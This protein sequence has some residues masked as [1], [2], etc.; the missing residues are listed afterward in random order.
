M[1]PYY[2][3]PSQEGLY[4]HF[5]TIA[6]AAD[7]PIV[8]YNIPGRCVIPMEL[9]TIQRLAAH[10]NIVA[11]K[12]AAG[13]LGLTSAILETTNLMLLSGDDPLTLPM[14]SVGGRGVISVISNVLPRQVAEL[15][16][17]ILDDR[18]DRARAVH[19]ELLPIARALLTLDSNPVPVKAVMAQ[20]GLD[21]GM[22][23]GPLMRATPEVSQAV[24]QLIEDHEALRSMRVAGKVTT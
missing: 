24:A 19:F 17:H 14:G 5:M 23:R 9:E 21:T 10:P 6:D 12:D 13:S 1:T 18:F 20:L 2:N 4:R 11:I 3:K 7:L 15:C 8:L 16:T 22:V